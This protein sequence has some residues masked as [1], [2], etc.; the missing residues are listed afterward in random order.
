MFPVSL[1]LL[2]TVND[3]EGTERQTS[4]ERV[5]VRGWG[6]DGFKGDKVY[7]RSELIWVTRSF[8]GKRREKKLL[9]GMQRM[10]KILK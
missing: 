5:S 4:S 7:E 9:F 2:G 10:N 1:R 3:E 8:R 6:R